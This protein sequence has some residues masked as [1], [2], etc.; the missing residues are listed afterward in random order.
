[1]RKKA[2]WEK[3]GRQP[4]EQHLNHSVRTGSIHF[5]VARVV[6]MAVHELQRTKR[7]FSERKGI[8]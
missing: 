8:P 1:M 2:S 5:Y 6:K 3:I 7:D 4:K